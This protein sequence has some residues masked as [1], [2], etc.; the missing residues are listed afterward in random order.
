[1]TPSLRLIN[2]QKDIKIHLKTLIL[3]SRGISRLFLHTETV[4]IYLF[5]L[6]FH[7][8]HHFSIKNRF[9]TKN[10]L[11]IFEAQ[12]RKKVKNIEPQKN[13]TILIKKRVEGLDQI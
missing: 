4:L 12:F 2:Y 10:I 7:V 9:S 11:R 5:D 13:F 3:V 1:M 6:I 8:K